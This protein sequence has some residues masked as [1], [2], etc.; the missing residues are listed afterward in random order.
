MSNNRNRQKYMINIKP[1]APR[2]N[3]Y[4]KTHKDN[5]PVRLVIDN[6][7]APSYKIAKFLD[8]RIREY[9]NLPTTYTVQNSN[10]MA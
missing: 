9:V 10:E 3:A 4:I 6:T 8:C 7:Q 2:I 1:T 5:N